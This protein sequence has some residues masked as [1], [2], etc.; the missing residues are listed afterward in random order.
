MITVVGVGTEFKSCT[1]PFA[2]QTALRL[3]GNV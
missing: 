1:K 2:F 3:Q